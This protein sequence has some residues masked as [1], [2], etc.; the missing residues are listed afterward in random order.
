[1]FTGQLPVGRFQDPINYAPDIPQ[2]L[3]DL[4]ILALSQN[5]SL[6]PCDGTQFLALLNQATNESTNEPSQTTQTEEGTA[7]WSTQSAGQIKAELKPLENKII[8]LLTQQG[9][10]K[11]DNLVLLQALADI[12][13]LDNSA[14]HTFITQVT[15]QQTLPQQPIPQQNSP[16]N[17]SSNE[18]ED[19]NA[20]QLAAFILWVNT[21]NKHINSQTQL[22]SDSQINSLIEAGLST[23]NKTAAQLTAFIRAKQQKQTKKNQ[24]KTALSRLFN[25]LKKRSSLLLVLLAFIGLTFLYGQHQAQNKRKAA[26]E[27]AWSQTKQLNTIAAYNLYLTNQPEGSYLN[28]AKQALTEKLL[29]A[30][31]QKE[32]SKR[33]QLIVQQQLINNIQQELRKQGYQIA[34]TGKLDERTQH[35][36]KSFEKDQQLLI[37]GKADQL[38]LKKL[39]Q[40]YQQRDEQMWLAGQ[41]EKTLEAYQRYQKAFPQGEHAMQAVRLIK[42]LTLEK[43][44]Y[45][46]KAQQAKIAHEKLMI[47]R[48]TNALLNNMVTLPAA[49]FIMGCAVNNGCKTKEM[50]QHKVTL[51]TFSI[52]A[53]E[54]TFAQWDAC[55]TSGACSTQPNDES[56]GRANR[57]VIGISYRDI[58]NE[59]IPWLNEATGNNFSLPSEAQWEYAAKASSLTTYAWGNELDCLQARYSQFSGLCGNERKTATV[60][61]FQPNAFGLYDMHGNV[62]EWT[63]DCWNDSYHGSPT[64]GSAWHTG[65][66]SAG[67]LRGGS[68]LNEA[69]LLRATFR[70]GYSRSASANVNGFRLV[71]NK[72]P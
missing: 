13:Q 62:W 19:N 38:I 39:K 28:D 69:N 60:K 71:I 63:Q 59:F 49:Q 44:H 5:P 70:T 12:A 14:L 29:Q 1:M 34:Q 8:A 64:D 31:Q 2:A 21:V 9:E 53:T 37:T 58:I 72:Q 41:N 16:L 20:S 18:Q 56:W 51:A 32:H 42:Q 43:K 50:P 40:L 22:L 45:E 7:I 47:E 23:T 57:P 55:V 48:T 68:W 17:N 33:A 35:A 67:V 52:M 15:L 66:C 10:I 65:D 54:V 27:L 11:P 26:D 46:K 6:R 25:Q 24:I 30:L 4:I 61:S 3:N 36:I